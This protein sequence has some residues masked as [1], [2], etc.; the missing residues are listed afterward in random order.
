MPKWLRHTPRDPTSVDLPL[1]L[2]HFSESPEHTKYTLPYLSRLG[3]K[4]GRRHNFGLRLVCPFHPIYP[5]HRPKSADRSEASQ[6]SVPK[7]GKICSVCIS[8]AGSVL[9]GD[10][11]SA[12]VLC[13]TPAP[14]ADPSPK[15]AGSTNST[16]VSRSC[17]SQRS[18]LFPEKPMKNR[19]G[20][21]TAAAGR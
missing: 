19:V 21:M 12:P 15:A 14:L 4:V 17:E 6:T 11:S 10:I 5:H 2:I 8:L 1:S 20:F 7:G 13:T 18:I 3:G 9:R 16:Y